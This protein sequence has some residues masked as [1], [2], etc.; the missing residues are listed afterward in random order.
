MQKQDKPIISAKPDKPKFQLP[1][2]YELA[3]LA[4]TMK[5]GPHAALRL[6]YEAQAMKDGIEEMDERRRNSFFANFCGCYDGGMQIFPEEAI[7]SF[8]GAMRQ[9]LRYTIMEAMQM[10]GISTERTFFE[11][12]RYHFKTTLDREKKTAELSD[13]DK[14]RAIEKEM[15]R[16]SYGGWC[17]SESLLDKLKQSKRDKRAEIGRQNRMD[18]C[19][20][21]KKRKPVK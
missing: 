4:A 8:E 18:A 2:A 1:T 21:R 11:L 13:E 10:L 3:M 20:K 16:M 15:R 19:H 14:R 9:E 5:A 7:M 6:W 12:V 17:I